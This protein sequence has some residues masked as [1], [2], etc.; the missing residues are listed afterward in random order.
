MRPHGSLQITAL[1][2]S[3]L[4]LFVAGVLFSGRSY[5]LTRTPTSMLRLDAPDPVPSVLDHVLVGIT[6]KMNRGKIIFL[7]YTLTVIFTWQTEVD[8]WIITDNKPALSKVLHRWAFPGV[9]IH[10]FSFPP[11][12]KGEPFLDSD[13]S[14]Y[15][16]TWE[17]RKVFETQFKT[18]NHTAFIYLEDDTEVGWE[19]LLSWA[20]DA[21][22]L[23]DMGFSRGFWRTEVENDG[24][25]TMMD[26]LERRNMTGWKR[27][28]E[29]ECAAEGEGGKG[30]P[31]C[32][33]EDPEA[34]YWDLREYP[35]KCQHRHYISLHQPYMGMWLGT[36]SQVEKF[37]SHPLWR[38]DYAILANVS[39]PENIVYPWGYPERSTATSQLIDVPEGFYSNNVVP[40]DPNNVILLPIGRILHERNGY[41]RYVHPHDYFDLDG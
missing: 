41:E 24:E 4:A 37:I 19:T 25:E 40:W 26:F 5:S 22:A 17:H 27:I 2:L 12:F 14:Q 23:E 35:P 15:L 7:K 13:Q 8:V 32:N 34:P 10:E 6:F 11:D 33:L 18:G 3:L 38:K 1:R 16:M 28:V 31:C 30:L 39:D 29:V 20:I 21:P 36:R 9:R